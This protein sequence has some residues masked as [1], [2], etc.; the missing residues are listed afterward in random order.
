MSNET[1][2]FVPATDIVEMEDGVHIFMDLPGVSTENLSIDLKEDEVT[3]K[4]VSSHQPAV[5]NGRTLH[6]EF[7]RMDFQRTFTLSDMVDRDKI[8]ASLKDGVLNL[9]LP[10][11]EAMKPRKISIIG[12]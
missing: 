11:A 3:I 7:Q 4:G 6:S 5:E 2:Y 12:S 1:T 9:F 8:T 10:K